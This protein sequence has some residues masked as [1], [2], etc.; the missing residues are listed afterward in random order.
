MDVRIGIRALQTIVLAGSMIGTAL[1]AT[2]PLSF[3][4]TNNGTSNITNG[5]G[6]STAL[7]VPSSWNYGDTF[8][9]QPNKLSGLSGPLPFSFYD[10]YKFSVA[11]ANLSSITSTIDLRNS[12]Q[13]NHL[14]VRLYSGTSVILGN[15]GPSLISAWSTPIN[16]GPLTGTVDVLNTTLGIGNYLL[17]VRGDVTGQN[18][19]SYAGV[20]NVGAVPVPASVWLLS[21]AIAGLGIIR[22]RAG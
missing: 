19:G 10:D 6:I 5:T 15:P 16:V 2:L 22:R 4:T 21:S 14:E 12:F 9:A 18:G 11:S 13:I 7:S 3:T 20:L 1:A 17:E 8:F